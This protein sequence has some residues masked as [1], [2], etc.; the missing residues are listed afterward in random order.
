MTA[1]Q[2]AIQKVLRENANPNALASQ[3]KFVPGITKMYG[4]YTPV[5]N[6]LAKKYKEGG[7]ELVQALWK[8]G[9]WEERLIAGKLLGRIPKNYP[10]KALQI[11]EKFSDELKDWAVCDTLGMQALKPIVKTHQKEIFEFANRLSESQHFWQ[12]RLSLVL[13]EWYTRDPTMH[14]TIDMLILKLE[15]DPEYYVQKAVVWI[16]RNFKKGK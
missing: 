14:S 6:D 10:R 11:V 13:V 7:F 3:Q 4:V 2:E 8:S 9:S 16:K 15:K 12:R 1:Q 5:L